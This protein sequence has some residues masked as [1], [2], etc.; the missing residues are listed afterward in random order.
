MDSILS[1][2]LATA[3]AAAT[4]LTALTRLDAWGGRALE[5]AAAGPAWAQGLRVL[6]VKMCLGF[7]DGDGPGG[8]DHWSGE[9]HH[10]NCKRGRYTSGC[11]D[12]GSNGCRCSCRT[13]G[14]TVFTWEEYKPGQEVRRRQRR[15][16]H[17]GQRA[18]PPGAAAAGGAEAGGLLPAAGCRGCARVRAA[19][20]A[21]EASHE[22]DSNLW[23]GMLRG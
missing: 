21:G 20:A 23:V 12:G 15:R 11:D 16:A 8:D 5:A 3:L 7:R 14:C 9:G 2:E 13:V 1:S 19:A 4:Q 22:P 17:R 18:L 6:K 10:A